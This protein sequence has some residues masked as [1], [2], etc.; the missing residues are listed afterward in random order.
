MLQFSTGRDRHPELGQCLGK[1]SQMTR[2]SLLHLLASATALISLI[3]PAQAAAGPPGASC[4][5]VSAGVDTTKAYQGGSASAILG[6]GIGQ[7]F[8]ANDTLI[9]AV[10]VWRP[11]PQDTNYAPMKFWI[12]NVDTLTGAP[13]PFSAVLSGDSL[14]IPFGDHIHATAIR[15]SFSPPFRLPHKGQYAFVFQNMCAGYFDLLVDISDDYPFGRS[16]RTN[17]SNFSGCALAGGSWIAADL[18]F[19]ID[20]CDT[21]TPVRQETWGSV[22]VRYR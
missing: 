14:I 6:E 13:Q 17:R 5:V 15:Y 21:M 18:I 22:K 20:F 1:A 10:T 8:V 4:T 19:T 9:E 16:F 3:S 7:T 12:V 11:A 2:S